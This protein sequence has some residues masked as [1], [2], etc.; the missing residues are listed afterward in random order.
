MPEPTYSKQVSRQKN[1]RDRHTEPHI[2][3][4]QRQTTNTRHHAEEARE[5]QT[6]K[7]HVPTAKE[8]FAHVPQEP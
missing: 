3:S 4:H 1:R 5:K 2:P 8:N 6:E 7:A